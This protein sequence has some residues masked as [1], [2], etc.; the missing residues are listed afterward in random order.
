MAILLVSAA[1]SRANIPPPQRFV[2][3]KTA[4]GYSEWVVVAGGDDANFKGQQEHPFGS[5]F[6]TEG[7]CQVRLVIYAGPGANATLN[8]MGTSDPH[9]VLGNGHDWVEEMPPYSFTGAPNWKGI[10]FYAVLR[11]RFVQFFLSTPD[12]P[13]VR[14][15]NA[16]IGGP[17]QVLAA[18]VT[19]GVDRALQLL[20]SKKY[21]W[22][23]PG[24]CPSPEP[25]KG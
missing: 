16:S 11:H 9:V 13:G 20:H 10:F 7:Y 1:G 5:V 24:S 6:E 3:S 18:G 4:P 17:V 12:K 2:P 21:G 15:I 23:P 8:V 22:T 19:P 25:W 14:D